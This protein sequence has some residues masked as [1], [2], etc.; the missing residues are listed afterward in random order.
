MQ[1]TK[2]Y[3]RPEP[4]VFEP[5][6]YASVPEVYTTHPEAYNGIQGGAVPSGILECGAAP[7]A[8]ANCS[9]RHKGF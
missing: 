2:Y 5:E 3:T 1:V 4:E 7:V 8:C 9:G 6:A